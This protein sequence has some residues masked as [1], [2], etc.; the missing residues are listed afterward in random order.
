MPSARDEL[1]SA[2]W[3]GRWVGNGLRACVLC[4]RMPPCAGV[5]A[6][7]VCFRVCARA[8]ACTCARLHVRSHLRVSVRVC[9]RACVQGSCSCVCVCVCERARVPKCVSWAPVWRTEGVLAVVDRVQ[10]RRVLPA[11]IDHSTKPESP[12]VAQ[13]RVVCGSASSH[14]ARTAGSTSLPERTGR[15]SASL[16]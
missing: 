14:G 10:L 15:D 12:R 13:S 1:R 2:W 9:S 16:L 7:C 6:S 3:V 4:T 5:R 8:R 11:A